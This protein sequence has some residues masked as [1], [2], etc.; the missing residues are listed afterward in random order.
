MSQAAAIAA[1]SAWEPRL[2][3]WAM[4]ASLLCAAFLAATGF[5]GWLGQGHLGGY[6][7]MAHNSVAGVFLGALAAASL[8]ALR[9][10]HRLRPLSAAAFWLFAAAGLVSGGSMLVAM[11]PLLDTPGLEAAIVLHRASGAAAAL[12][13]IGVLA[14]TPPKTYLQGA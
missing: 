13:A 5:A 9:T 1:T 12:A 14:A 2:L 11:T 8:L 3:G 7:L 4:G 6:P 10:G